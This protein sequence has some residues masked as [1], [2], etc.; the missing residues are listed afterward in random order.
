[1]DGNF[2]GY[3]AINHRVTEVLQSLPACALFQMSSSITSNHKVVRL[4][5]TLN[6]EGGEVLAGGMDVSV[7]GNCR[8]AELYVFID[9]NPAVG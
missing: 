3:D 5:W 8:I 4:V 7:L 9:S 2:R 1:M 6:V